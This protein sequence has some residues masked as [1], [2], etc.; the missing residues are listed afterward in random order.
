MPPFKITALDDL[1][2]RDE[3]CEITSGLASKIIPKTPIGQETLYKVKSSSSSLIKSS[4]LIGSGSFAISLI[5]AIISRILFSSN[6][7]RLKV[8]FESSPEST[9]G[10]ASSK[11]TLFAEKISSFAISIASA[12]ELSALF[13]ISSLKDAV[14]SEAALAFLAI[15]TKSIK[16]TPYKIV[17]LSRVIIAS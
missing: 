1:I 10:L 5:P 11:S 15:S 4:L 13:L 9:R 3:I 7:K 17:I 14:K 2:A 8:D 6:F 16:S 12:I